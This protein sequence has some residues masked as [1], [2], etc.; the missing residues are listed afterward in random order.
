M[1]RNRLTPGE[2]QGKGGPLPRAEDTFH[3]PL[4]G[5]DLPGEEEAQPHPSHVVDG[6]LPVEPLEDGPCSPS[7]CPG[8][9]RPR[10]SSPKRPRGG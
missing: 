6:G 5:D 4:A 8:R 9:C 2:E 7:G 10:R 3:S 1:L